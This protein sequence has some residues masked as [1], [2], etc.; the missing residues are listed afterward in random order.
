MK[1]VC[2]GYNHWINEKIIE[3]DIIMLDGIKLE[4]L[5]LFVTNIES[6][7]DIDKL[8]KDL[9]GIKHCFPKGCIE[10]PRDYINDGRY[11]GG[12]DV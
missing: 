10:K 9:D 2:N 11:F 5:D 6:S 12:F 8:I 3:T 1:T 4:S 7:A